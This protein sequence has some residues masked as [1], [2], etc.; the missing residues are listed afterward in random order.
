MTIKNLHDYLYDNRTPRNSRLFIENYEKNIVL[1]NNVKL[2]NITDYEYVMRLTCDYAIS[3]ESLGYLKKGIQN[4]DKAIDL[5]EKFPSYQKEKLFEF[6][7]YE[8]AKFH[9][10]RA[11]Y[12]MKRYKESLLIFKQLDNAFPNNDKYISWIN[13]IKIRN[14]NRLTN[15]ASAIMLLALIIRL[16]FKGRDELLDNLSLWFGAFGLMLFLVCEI[17]IRLQKLKNKNVR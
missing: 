3:L 10:A 8:L 12:N 7:Y 1:I 15:I 4:L 14:F 2:S 5:M 9:K 17:L 16:F 6:Q 11:L 13:G